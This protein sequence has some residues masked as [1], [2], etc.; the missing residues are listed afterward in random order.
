[1]AEASPRFISVGEV[2]QRY[3]V[4]VRT[5][6]RWLKI[7]KFPQP[8]RFGSGMTRWAITDLDAHDLLRAQERKQ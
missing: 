6:C 7:D 3:S 8:Y 1:M 5:I 2:A 4:S